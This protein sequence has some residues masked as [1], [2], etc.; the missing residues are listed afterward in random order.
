VTLGMPPA[1][2]PLRRRS[3]MLLPG[4]VDT[5]PMP[6]ID[7]GGGWDTIK[8][9]LG[10][11]GP[12]FKPTPFSP[13]D[14]LGAATRGGFS[15]TRAGAA[16]GARGAGDRDALGGD[17]LARPLVLAR[18]CHPAAVGARVLLELAVQRLAIEAEPRR[19]AGLVAAFGGEHALDVLALQLSEGQAA[20]QG[21]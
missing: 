8:S 4:G 6:N 17:V 2:D 18:R 19:G 9:G 12:F 3:P 13:V 14:P 10:E 15:R 21:R 1:R 11:N 16:A 20:G 7:F 5:N